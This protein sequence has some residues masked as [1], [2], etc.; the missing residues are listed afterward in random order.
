S[1]WSSD[2]C[3]SDLDAGQDFSQRALAR[4]VLANE[5]VATAAVNF[6]TDAVER[7]DAGEMFGDVFEGEKGH[8]KHITQPLWAI[9]GDAIHAGCRQFPGRGRR[10]HRPDV[11]FQTSV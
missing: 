8:L 5:R 1:D 6:K 9:G 10:I 2:V 7:Q 4:A 3:S 11:N